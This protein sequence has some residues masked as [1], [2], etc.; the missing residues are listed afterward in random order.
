MLHST[1]PEDQLVN[2]VVPLVIGFIGVVCYGI[3][4]SNPNGYHW[5]T[6]LVVAGFQFFSSLAVFVASTTYAIECFPDLA[7]PIL[8]TVGAYRN[9]I[10][11][12]LIQG[13]NAFVAKAGFGGCFGTYAGLV[14]FVGIVG[15]IFYARGETIRKRINAWSF[16]YSKAAIE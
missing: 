4:A 16:R 12:G 15:I 13:S 7:S 6:V 1:Q 11:F 9:I 2:M 3:M 5:I 14:G 10:G 8:I